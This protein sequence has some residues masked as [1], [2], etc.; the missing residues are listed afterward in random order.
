MSLNYLSLSNLFMRYPEII[1]SLASF[2]LIY[3]LRCSYRSSGYAIPTNW[4]LIGML[5]SL[6]VNTENFNSWVAAVLRE[7]GGNFLFKGPWFTG[8]DAFT[9][10]DP[11]NVNHIF[12]SN[13]RNYPKGQEF[14]EV[15]DTL[16]DGIS[17]SD[18]DS[19]AFQRRIGISLMSSTKFRSSMRAASFK[20][21]TEGLL[22]LL[23]WIADG[24]RVVNLCDV[25]M[26]FS[27]DLSLVM[28]LGVDPGYLAPDL[29]VIPFATAMV[30]MENVSFR[31]FTTP[32]F[33]WKLKRRFGL[34]EE[35]ILPPAQKI[36]DDFLAQRIEKKREESKTSSGG[37]DV[38]LLSLLV[39]ICGQ[40]NAI[41]DEF[42]RD[43]LLSFILASKDNAGIVLGWFFW[44]VSLN[45]RVEKKILDELRWSKPSSNNS[46]VLIY[47]SLRLYPPVP[48]NIKLALE[49]DVLP[50]GHKV[51]AGQHVFIS[52][53][54]IA[55]MEG[56]WGK[57]CLEFRPERWIDGRTGRLRFEP[58]CKFLSFHCGPRSCVGKN[59]ALVSIK[60]A[61]AA[62][63]Y[64]F[65]VEV[66]EGHVVEPSLSIL[67]LMKNGLRVRLKK[68]S[69]I[70]A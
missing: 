63:M 35:R 18:G 20:K 52:T 66:E 16:G 68:R 31:R 15:L 11:A 49:D 6:A 28:V 5:P 1:L 51:N 22:P 33:W 59:M 8:M 14:S 40:D 24:N 69:W 45:P 48:Y 38:D 27:F 37:E 50:S 21:V 57:D 26:R 2:L 53:Y 61:A 25:L 13:F 47:E 36:V 55:R 4:P 54:A 64:N 17:A 7:A 34:G 44:L 30:E 56:V 65:E 62:L 46:K 19:W 9:T 70:T 23:D 42:L 10:C 60:M 41:S 58:S 3:I 12:S 32:R 29:R 67:L 39:G 43:I